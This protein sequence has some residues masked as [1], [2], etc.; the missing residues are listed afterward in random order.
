MKSERDLETPFLNVMSPS[1]A[2]PQG[3][4]NFVEEESERL[5]E[6]IG[7]EDT[8]K[9]GPSGHSRDD[10]HMNLETVTV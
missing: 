4:W 6:P 10:A 5:K 2:S 8:K 3:S 7:I 1:N 9:A